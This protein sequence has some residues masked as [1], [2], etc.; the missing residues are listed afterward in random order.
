M[1]KIINMEAMQKWN[2]LP[3][4]L[5]IRILDNVFCG[6]CIVTTIVEYDIV[7]SAEGF[8][9]LKGKCKKCGD[10]VARVVD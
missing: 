8:V 10:N 7:L 3:K 6:N 9:L 2:E 5:Q 4:D 1:A